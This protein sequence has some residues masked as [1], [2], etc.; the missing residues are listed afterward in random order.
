MRQPRGRSI[1]AAA[2]LAVARLGLAPASAGPGDVLARTP[3]RADGAT[4]TSIL[5]ESTGLDG[6]PI[7]VS[8]FVVVPDGPPPVG[9]RPIVAWAHPTTGVADKCAPSRGS[10]P[11]ARIP[12]LP[13]ML[14]RGWIVAATDY[15]GLGTPGTHPYLVGISEGRSVLDSVR[16]ARQLAGRAAGDRFVVWGHSQGGQAALFTG[17]LARGYAPELH[18]LGIAAAAPASELANLFNDDLATPAGKVLTAYT[19]YSWSRVYGAPLAPVLG[20]L[21]LADVDRIAATCNE[22]L[23]GEI[24]LGIDALS[25]PT[26]FLK[27]ADITKISP[28]RGLIA[29]NTPTPP[30]GAYPIF[31]A[32]GTADTIVP[33]KVTENY[34]GELCRAGNPVEFDLMPGVSHTL[35]GFSSAPLAVE[36]MGGRFAGLPAPNT[37][38]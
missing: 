15:P 4:I 23:E 37:C 29:L 26:Q 12:G 13:A 10:N 24:G 16:A 33:Y 18:L 14:A 21:Q 27:V 9:G 6:R 25:L 7:Q 17:K 22:N 32:Q 31:L 19:L 28:W 11:L 34:L 30:I 8:G 5:Y 36:W 2:W 20:P 35:A 38:R 3:E 1:I